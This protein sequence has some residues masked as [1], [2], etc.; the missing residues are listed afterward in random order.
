MNSMVQDLGSR[1]SGMGYGVYGSGSGLRVWGLGRI[2]VKGF[3]GESLH[4]GRVRNPRYK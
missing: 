1:L 3:C 4:T 2:R